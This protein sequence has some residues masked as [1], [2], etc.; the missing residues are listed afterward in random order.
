MA[1][2]FPTKAN[3]AAG[4]VLTASALDDLAGTVNTVQ[5]LKPWNTCLN[6]N[7]SIWQRGTSGVGGTGAA[8]G[9]VADRWQTLRT[10]YVAGMTTSRQN[11]SDTTN[12]PNIQYCARVQRDSGNTSTAQL[13]FAQSYETVNSIPLAGK[14]IVLSFYARA[15]ANYS[16][17]SNGLQLII[18][19]GTGTD[20]NITTGYTGNATVTSQTATLTTTW[21]RFS[22][23]ATVSSSATEIGIFYGFTPV[24]TAGAADYYEITGI[25]LEQGSVANTYQPNQA[26]YES[27]LLA[28]QRYLPAFTASGTGTLIGLISSPTNSYANFKLPVTARVAP[29]GIS[30]PAVSNFSL[31][32]ATLSVGTPTAVA[33]D[34]ATADIALL[35]ITTTAGSPTIVAGQ[36]DLFRITSTGY[37]LFTGCEL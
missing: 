26:T 30:I 10:G 11:T 6:S 22:Y 18:N 33:F 24:G 3:W 23:T 1:V 21:Q 14:Q 35:A 13:Q 32:N 7:M 17:A 31:F 28:C 34:S 19:S 29:T 36:V 15:G 9:Y 8:N 16:A 5:Y 20:Q 4:D 12:L 25:Q 37:I 27:E 2:G